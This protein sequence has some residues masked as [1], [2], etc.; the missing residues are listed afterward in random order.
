MAIVRVG[1]SART[2]AVFDV[3]EDAARAAWDLLLEFR[4][5]QRQAFV[6]GV[7]TEYLVENVEGPNVRG[8]NVTRSE[9]NQQRVEVTLLKP[10]KD[11]Q[12]LLLRLRHGG[13][14]TELTVPNLTVEG[15]AIESGRVFIRRSPLLDVSAACQTC[16]RVPEAEL[17]ARAELI[18]ERT[19]K[20]RNL[21]LDALVELIADMK[22]AQD[23]S[24][25]TEQQL[26]P[27]RGSQRRAQFLLDFIEAENS[28]GFHADQ[29]AA[30]ILAESLNHARQGQI[31]LRDAGK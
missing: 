21:A 15:A 9:T 8:W 25:D 31:A 29:E 22:T 3:Q 24:G 10:A 1:S 23:R 18:Q 14:P 5:D 30:R 13:V 12:R 2:E 11:S 26:A 19:F 4:R 17:K 16:H 20:L 7:P 27:A 28:M 6:V